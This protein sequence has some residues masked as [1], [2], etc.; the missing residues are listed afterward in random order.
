MSCCYGA[1]ALRHGTSQGSPLP[2]GVI[3]DQRLLWILAK[4][5][6]DTKEQGRVRDWEVPKK[7][8]AGIPPA[9]RELVLGQAWVMC[10]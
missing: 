8:A 10:S 3:W 6:Q 7:T 4:A 2:L 5:R 1:L 9:G